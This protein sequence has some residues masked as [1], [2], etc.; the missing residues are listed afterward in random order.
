MTAII[1]HIPL[2]PVSASSLFDLTA[3]A[4]WITR[5]NVCGDSSENIRDVR[6]ERYWPLN[7]QGLS[8]EWSC[9][10]DGGRRS[11]FG[12][13]DRRATLWIHSHKD[14]PRLP[15]LPDCL[16]TDL[17]ADHIVHATRIRAR[18]SGGAIH[19]AGELRVTARVLAYRAGRRATILYQSTNT[20]TQCGWVAKVFRDDRAKA[21]ARIH[22]AVNDQLRWFTGG[23]VRTTSPVGVVD[24]L[25]MMLFDRV[26]GGGVNGRDGLSL[27]HAHRTAEAL[28]ALHRCQPPG[29]A[30]FVPADEV[31]VLRRWFQVIESVDSECAARW[32]STLECIE[33]MAANA[34]VVIAATIHRDC[35]NAQFLRTQRTTTLLDLD[36][37]AKGDPAIDLGNWIAHAYLDAVRYEQAHDFEHVCREIISAYRRTRSVCEASLRLFTASA[38]MRLAMVHAFRS[39]TSVFSNSLATFAQEICDRGLESME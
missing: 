23:S 24:P 2:Q 36:T 1:D 13:F 18:R 26:R 11:Y 25:K 33:R 16:D 30:P 9:A 19:R 31:S 37:L 35:Y 39:S 22:S 15:H 20:Q 4:L 17:M 3:A 6:V 27:E 29:L 14:D 28:T 7:H 5:A 21:L 34:P 8:I 32:R 38:A 12:R 10:T